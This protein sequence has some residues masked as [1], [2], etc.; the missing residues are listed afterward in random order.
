MEFQA[1]KLPNDGS[2]EKVRGK[3]LCSQFLNLFK[4][5]CGLEVSFKCFSDNSGVEFSFN[6]KLSALS[7]IG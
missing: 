2:C 5:G 4:D 7:V 1:L 3:K 6:T